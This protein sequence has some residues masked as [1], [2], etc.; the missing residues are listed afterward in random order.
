MNLTAP[1]I[2]LTNSYPRGPRERIAGVSMLARTIDK[3]R[4]QLAGTVGEYIYDCPMDRQLF[5]TL[6]I[7]GDEFLEVVSRSPDDIAVVAWLRG[8]DSMPEGAKLDAHNAAIEN[9]APKSEEGRARF[10]RQ[11][12]ALAP[13]RS[14]I[15]TWTDLLD[16]EEGRLS[17]VAG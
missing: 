8:R 17:P 10:E 6:G 3:A 13:G 1:L 4:A 2:D 16:I 14:D 9:W 7:T 5:A 15:T 11:R 12:E